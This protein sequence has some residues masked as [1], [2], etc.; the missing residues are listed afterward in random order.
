MWDILTFNNFVT[1]DILMFFYYIGVM[2]LPILL[3]IFRTYFKEKVAWLDTKDNKL[4]SLLLFFVLLFCMELCLRMFFE[5]LIGY[6]DM[7]DYLY[8][9]SQHLWFF[10]CFIDKTK[11]FCNGFI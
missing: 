5:F 11:Y 4:K 2:A 7:H 3:F 9:I 1:Q 8:T 10:S 6:F